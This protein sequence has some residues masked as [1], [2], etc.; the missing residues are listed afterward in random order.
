MPRKPHWCVEHV[1]VLPMPS[2]IPVIM[3]ATCNPPGD[4][5]TKKTMPV[6]WKR[7]CCADSK[8]SISV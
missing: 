7:F 8:A 2:L 1:G 6:D 3:A 4:E 5:Y